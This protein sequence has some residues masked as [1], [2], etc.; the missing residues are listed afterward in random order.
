MAGL[1]PEKKGPKRAHKLT[2]KV[3][4]FID[5]ELAEHPEHAP[6]DLAARIEKRFG[7]T[8]H[9]KSIGRA[10]ARREKNLGAKPHQRKA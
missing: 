10:R 2:A 8:I 9:P 1:L 3:L 7:V 5:A 6:A 4:A